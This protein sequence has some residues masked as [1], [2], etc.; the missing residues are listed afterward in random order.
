MPMTPADTARQH[1]VVLHRW[2]DSYAVYEDYIDH[3]EHDVTYVAT[4]VS[5]ASVPERAAAVVAVDDITDLDE[6]RAIV[7]GPVARFGPPAAVVALQEGDLRVASHLREDYG[8]PGRRWSELR[9]FLDKHAMLDAAIRTGVAVPP[10]REVRRSAEIADFAAGHGWPLV[11]KPLEGRASAGVFQLDGPD[12]LAA[13]PGEL[14]E[15]ILVQQRVPHRV[16][17]ADGYFDGEALEPWRVA[18][19]VN[20]PGS[21]IHGPLAFNDGAPVGEVE[22]TDARVIAAVEDFLMTLIPGMSPDPW[23][24]HCELFVDEHASPPQCTFLEVGCRPG[25]GEIPFVWREVYGIDLMAIEFDLQ[26]GLEPRRQPEHDRPP[27]GGSLLVPLTGP[28]PARITEVTSM[29]GRPGGP[30][31]EWVPDVGTVIPAVVGTYEYVGGRFRF[32]GSST[33][34]VARQIVA[35]GQDYVVRSEVAD[36][37]LAGSGS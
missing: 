11:A 25:G 4:R 21:P 7:R 27:I 20:M 31:A 37:T 14:P 32:S 19:Y 34:E 10:A 24:F 29:L 22:V 12:D 6:V 2:C 26:R 9:H 16:Y 5:A 35:T 17:H 28:R 33:A 23:V 1:V 15:P 3:A 30:Y 36:A 13:L 18:R 8:C